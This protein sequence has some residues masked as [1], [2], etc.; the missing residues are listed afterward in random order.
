M[1][2]NNI[3]LANILGVNANNLKQ[4]KKRG[5][6]KQ[7]LQDRGYKILGQVK[8][9]RQV[10]Y[11][12][13]KEDDNKE[14]LNNIIYYMFGTREFKKFCKYYLYRLANLDRPLTTELLSKLVGVNIHTITK[15]DNKMLANNILSQDG[16]WYIAID[17]WED[18]KETYRNTDIWEYNSFAKNTRIAN[19]KTRAIQKYKTDK[20]NKQELEMLEDS[21]G[22]RREVIKNKFVYYVRK[23][24][25]KKGYKLSLDIVKLIK[26]VYNKNIANYF[27]N[28][29]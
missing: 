18:T 13:E 4:I 8:E 3:E 16:K 1:R 5:S 15:W 6:L 7:R 10:Y 9:G 22:I 29:I 26:E 19:S 21:I 2:I 24:K 23:Y 14:I 25:L 28:L 12:L 20:I 27:I 17:Y 11:E